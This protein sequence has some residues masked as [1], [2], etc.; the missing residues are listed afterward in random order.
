MFY[1]VSTEWSKLNATTVHF[2]RPSRLCYS[3]A[4][5][6]CLHVVCR[7]WRY[8]LRPNGAS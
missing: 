1:R 6:V 2:S 3:V 7:L 5:V 4:S 8:V